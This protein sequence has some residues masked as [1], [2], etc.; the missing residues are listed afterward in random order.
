MFRR[1]CPWQGNKQ[2][3]GE[4]S[5]GGVDVQAGEG[6]GWLLEKKKGMGGA[7]QAKGMGVKKMLTDTINVICL[8]P[9]E[10]DRSLYG[11]CGP[12]PAA[13]C[14]LGEAGTLPPGLRAGTLR[15]ISPFFRRRGQ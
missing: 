10:L 7:L 15:F 2:A 4:Q 3:P 13:L 6:C 9:P 1:L 12:S 11:L 14:G 8:L 5:L